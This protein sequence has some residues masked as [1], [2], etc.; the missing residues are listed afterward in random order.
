MLQ[1]SYR[2]EVTGLLLL[3]L[4]GRACA[5]GPSVKKVRQIIA[6]RG[7]SADRPECTLASIRRAIEAGA[8]AVE[9]DVRTTKD[10]RLVI[11]HDASLDRTTNGKGVLSET[12]F[13][14]LRRLD[15]GAWFNEKYAGQRVPTLQE[16]LATCKDKIDV[17]LDLKEQGEAYAKLVAKEV[18]IYGAPQRTIVGVRSVEQAMLI[19]RLLP[20]SQQLGLIPNPL[21]IEPFANVGVETIRLWPRWV[22]ED[23]KLVEQVRDAG[24]RL[25]LNG[26]SGSPEDVQPL[27]VLGPDSLSGDDPGRLLRTLAEL[28]SKQDG[29]R[30]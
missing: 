15:A 22:V 6:H 23:D 17:L 9:V 8:T 18:K 20:K 25:H 21:A 5:D 27:L 28:Q 29:K 24:V 14:E 26:T 11:L 7:S 12:N 16:V 13:A 1:R 30:D 2:I 4:A 19:R 10:G 3:L